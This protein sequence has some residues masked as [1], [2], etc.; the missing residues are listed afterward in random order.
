MLND[1]RARLRVGDRVVLAG[2]RRDAREIIGAADVLAIG[3]RWEG[4]PL[5]ALEAASAHTPL[6]AT[7]VRGIR[8]LLMHERHCL[9]VPSGNA[10]TFARALDR[11]LR[12]TELRTRLVGDASALASGF[13]IEAMVARFLDLFDEVAASSIRSN[14]AA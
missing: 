7:D 10:T 12:D 5:V 2:R 8:E 9:L 1:L 6:V 14:R 11:M 13:T 4:L 3:S